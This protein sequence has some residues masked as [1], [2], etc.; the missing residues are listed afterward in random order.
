MRGGADLRV[1]EQPEVSLEHLR[2]CSLAVC[3][4][5]EETETSKERHG[6]VREERNC[7][8]FFDSKKGVVFSTGTRIIYELGSLVDNRMIR[9][10]VF[11]VD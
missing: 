7:R 9:R 10:E 4:F 5:F 11:F 8:I 3:D 6:F 2:D 1:R